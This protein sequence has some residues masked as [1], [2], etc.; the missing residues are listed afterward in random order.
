MKKEWIKK[1]TSSGV[2]TTTLVV[3]VIPQNCMAS[4]HHMED[5]ARKIAYLN[6][7]EGNTLSFDD[8]FQSKMTHNLKRVAINIYKA[9]DPLESTQQFVENFLR[10]I[11]VDRGQFVSLD[12]H[13]TCQL[14][15]ENADILPAEYQ[16]AL[17]AGIKIFESGKIPSY[18]TPDSYLLGG[19]ASLYWPWEWNW[20]GLNKHSNKH[21]HKSS[22]SIK[23]YGKY[24]AFFLIVVSLTI[25]SVKCPAA[26]PATLEALKEA[27]KFCNVV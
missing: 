23:D 14:L 15:R 3:S 9:E 26:I 7:S 12:V 8:L 11:Q 22:A 18:G 2:L 19:A 17:H 5:L 21:S 24:I 6:P 4:S 25:V 13:T 16:D 1:I 10:D 20:F 27:A